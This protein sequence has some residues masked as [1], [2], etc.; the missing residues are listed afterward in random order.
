MT[1]REA[2]ASKNITINTI[3][4]M[5]IFTEIGA[6]NVVDSQAPEQ[7]ATATPFTCFKI[8]FISKAKGNK[9]KVKIDKLNCPAT[10]YD[11]MQRLHYCHT[12][13]PSWILSKA[14]NLASSS[15]QDGATKWLYDTA[16]TTQSSSTCISEC[17]RSDSYQLKLDFQ[18]ANPFLIDQNWYFEKSILFLG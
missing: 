9:A 16:G 1:S 12:R 3:P 4:D 14:D 10:S 13:A 11:D 7:R 8:Y 15:L 18:I 2:I 6:T 17:G 5:K